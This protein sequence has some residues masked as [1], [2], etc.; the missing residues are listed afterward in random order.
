MDANI[1]TADRNGPPVL[2]VQGLLDTI[3]LPSEEA[4]CNIEKLQADGVLPT[5]CTDSGAQ[6]TDILARDVAYAVS[7]VDATLARQTPPACS[8]SGMPACS[9]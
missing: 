3:M 5:I 9:P 7:W 8:S 4:A 6:H 2:Y 1:L